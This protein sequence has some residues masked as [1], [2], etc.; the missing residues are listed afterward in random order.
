MLDYRFKRRDMAAANARL[1]GYLGIQFPWQ[2]GGSGSE[3]TPPGCSQAGEQ[4]VNLDIALAAPTGRAA[5]RMS[6]VT[7]MDA[8]TIHRLLEVEWDEDDRPVFR[9]I[10][11]NPL[12]CNALILDEL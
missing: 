2:S 7:G 12:D 4:H 3:V 1:N 10:S 8:K 6:E 11:Q 5:K 9:R